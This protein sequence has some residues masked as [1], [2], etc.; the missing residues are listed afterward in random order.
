MM[1]VRKGDVSVSGYHKEGDSYQLAINHEG[2]GRMSVLLNAN[3]VTKIIEG[4][5]D[6]VLENTETETEKEKGDF[7][8]NGKRSSEDD[9]G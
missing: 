3:E 8:D 4:L 7:E 1:I 5:A 2:V 6:I 9:N